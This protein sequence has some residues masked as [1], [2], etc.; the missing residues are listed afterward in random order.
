MA[1]GEE[2]IEKV[3]A[4]MGPSSNVASLSVFLLEGEKRPNVSNRMITNAIKKELGPIYEA[5][6]LNFGL[7]NIFGDPV[8]ISLLG[9]NSA[10]I[11]ACVEDLKKELTKID[12]LTD[13]QDNNVQGL[14]EI[15][16]N[17]KPKAYN[18][19]ITLGQVMQY[20]RQGFFGAE[21]QRLQRGADEVKVWVRLGEEDRSSIADLGAMRFRTIG[22]QSIPL[23]ELADFSVERGVISLNHLD[24]Q[25]EVRVTADVSDDKVS[26]S[27]INNDI[28]NVLLPEILKRYPS[29]KVGIEG[30]A[31]ENAEAQASMMKTMPLIFLCMFFIIVITFSSV[32]QAMIVFMMIPFGFIGVGFGHW[33]MDKPLSLLSIL[34]VIALIGILV[35]DALVFISTFNDKIK[36]GESF[37]NA[38]Y[39][40]GISRFRP[41]TLTTITTVAGLMPLMLEKSVQAQFLIPMAISVAFGLMISTFILLVLIPALMVMASD[42]RV[43]S[44]K[45]WTGDNYSRAMAEPAY[46]GRNMPWLLT[47]V[48]ALATLIAVGAL[49]FIALQ[50]SNFLV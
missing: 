30:Q 39:D 34:G 21:I 48:F 19:G 27:D 43:F 24:G 46:S 20:V 33:F 11:E 5:E 44:L 2:L 1:G 29:V 36:N 28:N 3:V 17:L 26:V 45:M 4:K 22:G 41:I 13:I 14:K 25:R 42:I 37:R 40:T 7:G 38:L 6:K 47:L 16:V 32:S 8:S 10:E 9:T 35:N 31:K 18:L 23:S 49:V 50:I 12:E 15:E